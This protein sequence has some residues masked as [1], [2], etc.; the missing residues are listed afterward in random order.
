MH[1]STPFG[2]PGSAAQRSLR[3]LQIHHLKQFLMSV[4]LL[5]EIFPLFFKKE[6]IL[7]RITLS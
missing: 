5:P 4:A 7:G 3:A 6:I 1:A 2:F